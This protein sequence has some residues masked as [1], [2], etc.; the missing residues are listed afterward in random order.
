M[1]NP[2]PP[3]NSILISTPPPLTLSTTTVPN[4]QGYPIS[5]NPTTSPLQLNHIHPSASND[6]SLSPSSPVTISQDLSNL[7]L[8]LSQSSLQQN[9]NQLSPNHLQ[10]SYLNNQQ[11]NSLNN[12]R[13]GTH[14]T[15]SN[16]KQNKISKI[17]KE[18]PHETNNN[19]SPNGV[20]SRV[21]ILFPRKKTP[22]GRQTFTKE[23][24]TYLKFL[25]MKHGATD[26]NL[27]ASMMGSRT[28]RQC[29]ERY[30]NYL[31]PTVNVSK[32][33]NEEDTLLLSKYNE[34]GSR[35]T[36]IARF[37]NSRTVVNVKNR[38]NFL[39][40]QNTKES[41]K[42]QT[43]E[44]KKDKN[45]KKDLENEPDCSQISKPL[46]NPIQSPFQTQNKP[47]QNNQPSLNPE[48]SAPICHKKVLQHFPLIEAALPPTGNFK[49]LEIIGNIRTF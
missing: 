48:T 2:F 39:L 5:F 44:S 19:A 7:L 23:E 36:I 46:L 24:D 11:H 35:W 41:E 33:S 47:I 38:C 14:N 28:S 42:D 31:A 40:S 15:Q 22:S 1:I 9:L 37:F 29:R 25:V 10:N 12:L 3:L 4:E 13:K 30:R 20:T 8:K 34:F 18:T 32:W 17:Y 49:A 6:K 16:S 21:N 26:W 27:I 43:N 45:L